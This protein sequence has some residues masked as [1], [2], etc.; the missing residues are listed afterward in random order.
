[1]PGDS[2]SAYAQAVILVVTVVI[3]DEKLSSVPSWTSYDA[4]YASGNHWRYGTPVAVA[5][6]AG[7]SWTGAGDRLV[8]NPPPTRL[9]VRSLS[10][11]SL[12]WTRQ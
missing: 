1:V 9:T 5:V 6:S 4:A 2:G 7:K 10:E 3:G 12:A 11:P 8:T